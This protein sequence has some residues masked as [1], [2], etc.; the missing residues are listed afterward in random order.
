MELDH[1]PFTCRGGYDLSPLASLTTL[2]S[3][4]LKIG[5]SLGEP[6]DHPVRKIM[7]L[8]KLTNLMSPILHE[9]NM[10]AMPPAVVQLTRLETLELKGRSFTANIEVM[11]A[12][13]L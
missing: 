5:D 8:E 13:V 12:P 2:K 1:I 4:S 3:L 11:R 7:G 9:D 6:G 10:V